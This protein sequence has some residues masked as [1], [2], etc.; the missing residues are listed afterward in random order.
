[1]A[2]AKGGG[3]SCHKCV[4]A[5]RASCPGWFLPGEAEQAA[6]LLNMTRDEF[7][8]RYCVRDFW[9]GGAKVLRP[10]KVTDAVRWPRAVS[11]MSA[12]EG[13]ACVLL[14]PDGRC[15]IHEAKP[16]ECA[17]VYGCGRDIEPGAPGSREF[18]QRAWAAAGYPEG[19]YMVADEE[20]NP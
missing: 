5:C 1:M 11:Y 15:L 13:S 8:H 6:A 12:W 19:G 16:S 10:A 4:N 14:T 9:V 17:L 2:T 20:D 7:L 3:C 18:I